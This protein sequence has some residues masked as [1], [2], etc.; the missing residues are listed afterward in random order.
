MIGANGDRDD[1]LGV[2][3][4]SLERHF[5]TG[6]MSKPPTPGSDGQGTDVDIAVS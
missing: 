6:H 5:N 2:P 3:E 1:V 4:L